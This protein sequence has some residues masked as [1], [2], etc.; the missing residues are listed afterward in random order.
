MII[1]QQNEINIVPGQEAP[2]RPP[3]KRIG[4]NGAI[5]RVVNKSDQEVHFTISVS[6]SNPYWRQ[7]WLR[8]AS[9]RLPE[10]EQKGA[11]QQ[12]KEDIRLAGG[13]LSIHVP[14]QSEQLV[15]I[16][17]KV[18]RTP[19][20]RAGKYPLHISVQSELLG[21]GKRAAP[22]ELFI[23]AYI[24]S[25]YEWKVALAEP[26]RRNVYLLR[27]RASFALQIVNQGNDW[28]YCLLRPPR[29]EQPEAA[30]EPAH[31]RAGGRPAGTRRGVEQARDPA[32]SRHAAQNF[33]WVKRFPAPS[34]CTRG[35][36]MPPRWR[37]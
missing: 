22:D 15:M 18:P 19:E 32:A 12:I 17:F 24:A 30:P 37:S 25:Y 6:C 9:L 36:L 4:E 20:A 29:Q 8:M 3:K 2:V 35:A 23:D 21:A 26:R 10:Q 31:Q 33:A 5:L 16:G 13:A 34:S 28:L 14:R 7:E 11:A 27:R 1:L